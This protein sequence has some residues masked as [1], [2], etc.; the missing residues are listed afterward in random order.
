MMVRLEC[1]FM[2][3]RHHWL[4][5][6]W[7]SH[8]GCLKWDR[9]FVSFL[10]DEM[11]RPRPYKVWPPM[12]ESNMGLLTQA[13]SWLPFIKLWLWPVLTIWLLILGGQIFVTVKSHEIELF[14]Y[15]FKSFQTGQMSKMVNRSLTASA[16]WMGY[17]RISFLRKTLIWYVSSSWVTLDVMTSQTNIK[18]NGHQ[19]E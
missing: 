16:C 14:L 6:I 15:H 10:N 7:P 18:W 2:P 13:R 17:K 12:S 8:I 4:I 3:T 9:F 5:I 19:S 1:I 11:V